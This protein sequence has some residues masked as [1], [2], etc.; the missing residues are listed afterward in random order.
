MVRVDRTGAAAAV[1][2]LAEWYIPV[3][4]SKEI[5]IGDSVSDPES[6]Y[7]APA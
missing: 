5:A 2:F 7:S 3:S 4:A 6:L 1:Y